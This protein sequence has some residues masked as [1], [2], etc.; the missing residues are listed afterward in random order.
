MSSNIGHPAFAGTVSAIVHNPLYMPGSEIKMAPIRLAPNQTLIL[1]SLMGSIT[2]TDLWVASDASASDGSEVPR[3]IILEDLTVGA[4]VKVF[5]L[6]FEGTFN[7]TA[8]TYNGHTSNGV[9]FPLSQVGIYL[10]A[11]RYSF[12]PE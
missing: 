9:R 4:D 8:L 5:Q 1:G 2:A 7:E 6:A 12:T 10:T 3:A 11:G